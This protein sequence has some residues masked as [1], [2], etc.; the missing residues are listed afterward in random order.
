MTDHRRARNLAAAALDFRP[1]SAESVE[2]ATHLATCAECRR[3]DADL[4][5][6]DQR[7]RS[8]P[9]GHAPERVRVAVMDAAVMSAPTSRMKPLVMLLAAFAIALATL[10]GVAL[11][12][13]LRTPEPLRLPVKTWTQLGDPSP[14]A[15]AMESDAIG[16]GINVLAIGVSSDPRQPGPVGWMSPDGNG[17]TRLPTESMPKDGVGELLAA[18]DDTLVVLGRAPHVAGRPVPPPRAW[19]MHG[20]RTC[21]SCSVPPPGNNLQPA[22]TAFPDSAT[23]PTIFAAFTHGPQGFIAVGSDTP[24]VDPGQQGPYGFAGL[25]PVRPRVAISPDGLDWTFNDPISAP[26]V[27]GGM[28]DVA[29]GETAIVA[30]G[31]GAPSGPSLGVVPVGG[32]TTVWRSTDG[33]AWTR[34]DGAF[35]PSFASVRSVAVGPSGFVAVG[36]E[37]GEAHAWRS[38]DGMR[39]TEVP[40]SPEMVGARMLLVRWLGS[41][42]VAIGESA[43]DGVAWHSADGQTWERFDTGA[44]LKAVAPR[45]I[46]AIRGRY[47]VFGERNDTQPPNYPPVVVAL[48]DPSPSP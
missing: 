32:A 22:V 48:G 1:T 36:D 23:T 41:E 4:R 6:D 10:A 17:W 39:W 25:G 31:F 38:P 14:F 8:R 24:F 30:L 44:T 40:T 42:F 43:G 20:A 35:M 19:V 26:F 7:A 12:G 27:A 29:A 15:D 3:Y 5:A 21:D 47:L 2:L 34:I 11:V 28:V 13:R 18:S 37:G 33:R 46:V 9:M 45:Q 16:T